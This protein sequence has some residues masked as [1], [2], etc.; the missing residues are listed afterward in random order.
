MQPVTTTDWF[1]LK[2]K[3]CILYYISHFNSIIR[4]IRGRRHWSILLEGTQELFSSTSDSRLNQT[5]LAEKALSIDWCKHEWKYDRP[6]PPPKKNLTSPLSISW[7][8]HS[9]SASMHQFAQGTQTNHLL[10][11]TGCMCE[12]RSRSPYSFA[13]NNTSKYIICNHVTSDSLCTT[14]SPRH[15]R[16]HICSS[17]GHGCAHQK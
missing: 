10:L 6:P 1:E 9:S 12:K 13:N 3:Y 8:P 14:R 2:R 16:R 17:S 7:I 11:E 5:S 15:V 4:I